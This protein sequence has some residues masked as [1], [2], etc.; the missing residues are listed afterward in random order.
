MRHFCKAVRLPG[1]V[2]LNLCA[3]IYWQG[4]SAYKEE[5]DDAAKVAYFK[6]A[7][8][9]EMEFECSKPIDGDLC[10]AIA[11]IGGKTEQEILDE[12]ESAM[13]VQPF[14]MTLSQSV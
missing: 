3:A 4:N 6:A 12:R 1:L 11:W 13:T 8:Q 5:R 7:L 10:E 9:E 14:E 2:C